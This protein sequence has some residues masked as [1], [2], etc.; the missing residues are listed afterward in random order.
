M[1]LPDAYGIDS[2]MFAKRLE[3]TDRDEPTRDVDVSID[4]R[5]RCFMPGPQRPGSGL[6]GSLAI[7]YIP[8]KIRKTTIFSFRWSWD[9]N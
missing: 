3:P 4:Q 2:W 5:E 9:W 7:W 6:T 8:D 1:I